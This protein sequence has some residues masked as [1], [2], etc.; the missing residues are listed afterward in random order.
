M[1]NFLCEVVVTDA[2]LRSPERHVAG[3]GGIVD[4]WGIVRKL[5]DEREIKG[6]DYEAHREMAEHQLNRIAEQAAETFSLQLVVIHHRVGFIAV[7][8]PSLFTRVASLHRQEA[9]QASQ[10]IVDELKKRVPIW[11]KPQFK[12]A[13]HSAVVCSPAASS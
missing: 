1:A 10:W 9:F 4:F 3:A 5:E 6:I 12:L 7:A 8:E 2:P 11:K 13:K